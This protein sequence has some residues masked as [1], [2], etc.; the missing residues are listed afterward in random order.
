MDNS[1]KNNYK[2]TINYNEGT[3]SWNNLVNNILSFIVDNNSLGDLIHNED[4]CENKK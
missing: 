2:I 1:S 4:N 3:E